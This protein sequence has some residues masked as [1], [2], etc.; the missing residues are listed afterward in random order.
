MV[1]NVHLLLAVDNAHICFV[2]FFRGIGFYETLGSS[3]PECNNTLLQISIHHNKV[4]SMA[5]A[6]LVFEEWRTS[7]LSPQPL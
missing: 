2:G 6:S 7:I 4:L 5:K 1:G 3:A